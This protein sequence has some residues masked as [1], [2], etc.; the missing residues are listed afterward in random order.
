MNIEIHRARI[1]LFDIN[2]KCKGTSKDR[3]FILNLAFFRFKLTFLCLLHFLHALLGLNTC[4]VISSL[5]RNH[6]EIKTFV[7][8]FLF[9]QGR[10]VGLSSI[11]HLLCLLTANHAAK[12]FITLTEIDKRSLEPIRVC[13]KICDTILLS[14][15]E[16]VKKYHHRWSAFLHICGD[17][18]RNPGQRYEDFRFMHWNANSLPTLNFLRIPLFKRTMQFTTVML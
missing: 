17:V 2:R 3:F 18:E 14:I 1:G 7:C 13:F 4:S 9:S 16:K 12:A 11:I 5:W 6:I 8:Y 10:L 15:I